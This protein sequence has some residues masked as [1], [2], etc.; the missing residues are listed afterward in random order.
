MSDD[1]LSS[2]F[3]INSD[4]SMSYESLAD[5]VTFV[6]PHFIKVEPPEDSQ[7]YSFVFNAESGFQ[8]ESVNIWEDGGMTF[9]PTTPQKVSSFTV[10]NTTSSED[11]WQRCGFTVAL[12]ST[13]RG[14][15]SIV[16]DPT[17]VNNPDQGG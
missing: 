1:T 11:G 15:Q 17:I 13:D 6:G 12:A 4:K 14:G 8:F 5:G 2:K 10:T 7:T 9:D 16:V 3:T